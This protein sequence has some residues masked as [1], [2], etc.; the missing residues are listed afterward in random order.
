MPFNCNPSYTNFTNDD[1][2]YGLTGP[3]GEFLMWCFKSNKFLR[4]GQLEMPV[5][6]TIDVHRLDGSSTNK[7]HW[8]KLWPFFTEMEKHD[9]YKR[10]MEALLATGTMKESDINATPAQENNLLRAKSKFGILHTIKNTNGHVHFVLDGLNMCET[11]T[12][13]YYEMDQPRGRSDG[14]EDKIRSITGSELRW[15]YRHRNVPRVQQRIQFWYRGNGQNFVPVSPP[16][17]DGNRFS[18]RPRTSSGAPSTGPQ[19]SWKSAWSWY[20]PTNEPLQL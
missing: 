1:I 13:T 6:S 9:K 8:G 20:H 3:R 14:A 2:A 4:N 5:Y 12:K 17:E 10:Y 18:A 15:I 7:S 16:W 11:A 19:V